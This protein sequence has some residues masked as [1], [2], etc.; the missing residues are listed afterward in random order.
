MDVCIT[1]YNEKTFIDGIRAEGKAE[2]MVEGKI[3]GI[4]EKSL[5]VYANCLKRGMSKEDAIAISGIA[6]SDI[7]E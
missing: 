7:P 1:E 2:G 4:K 5:Q 3:E 6:E